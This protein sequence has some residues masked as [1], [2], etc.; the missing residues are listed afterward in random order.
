MES[1]VSLF[2]LACKVNKLVKIKDEISHKT[3][4]KKE[5]ATKTD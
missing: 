4:A 3:K 1:K 2:I 5:F